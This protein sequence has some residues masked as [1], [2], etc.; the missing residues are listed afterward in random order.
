MRKPNIF[1]IAGPNGAG[2]ST[3]AQEFLPHFQGCPNFVNADLIASGLSPFDPTQV[4]I[5]AGRL[6]L[7][8]INDF[9]QTKQDFG[10]ESTL[11]GKSYLPLIQRAKEKGFLVHIFFLWVSDVRLVKDRIKQRVKNGGHDVPIADIERRYV[12]S[13]INF[14]R[15]YRELCDSWFVFDNSLNTPKLIAHTKNGDIIIK[16]KNVFSQF[17]EPHNE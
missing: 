17:E 8:Q 10:F 14:K 4:R 13:P 12:R 15:Y 5:K 9:L 2:K 16:N 6:L 11:S 3:F 7:E 1:I